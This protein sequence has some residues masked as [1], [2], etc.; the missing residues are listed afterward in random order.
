MLE[1]PGEQA[2][3][4]VLVDRAGRRRSYSLAPRRVA[5]ETVTG[6]RRTPEG[7]WEHWVDPAERIAFL[8]I[9][10]LVPGTTERV[11]RALRA[12]SGARAVVLDLR[13]NPGGRLEDG[14]AVANLFL[15]GGVVFT[16]V[17]RRGDRQ[18]FAA[19]SDG[20]MPDV[21]MV[22]LV[23][24]QTASAAEIV[25]GALR[26]H[27][28]AVLVG[29]RT[30]GKGLVQSMIS[31]PDQLGQANLTTGEF[32]L[33]TDCPVT[34]RPGAKTWGVEPH[35]RLELSAPEQAKLRR[36]WMEMDVMPARPA[37]AATSPATSPASAPSSAPA[38]P[39]VLRDR[40]LAVALELLRAR[41]A[42]EKILAGAA[43]ER[44][45]QEEQQARRRRELQGPGA[46]AEANQHD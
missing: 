30:R 40:Q 39:A 8:R 19:Q 33:G 1:G 44:K 29:T 14:Y 23:N 38:H 42:V 28:R 6:L 27:D 25:A 32:F 45:R 7:Q 11:H 3:Q 26:L 36:F 5:L 35:R 13:D 22:V 10:E 4:I 15:R 2:V 43:A 9:K 20:T 31:L 21:P 37:A 24:E 18:S 12:A 16:K 34:R 17:D 41:G 46:A